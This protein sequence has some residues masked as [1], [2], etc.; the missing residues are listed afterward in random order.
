MVALLWVTFFPQAKSTKGFINT[1]F[2]TKPNASLLNCKR[3]VGADEKL[4]YL[5][6]SL[7]IATKSE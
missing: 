2:K 6:D 4:D 7:C 3:F 5:A 1:T